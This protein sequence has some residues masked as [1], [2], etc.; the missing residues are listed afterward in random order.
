M[1]LESTPTHTLQFNH[2][3]KA[4]CGLMPECGLRA[5]FTPSVFPAV[6]CPTRSI[7]GNVL[8]CS[9]CQ[10]HLDPPFL[11]LSSIYEAEKSYQE[12]HHNPQCIWISTRA[13][14]SHEDDKCVPAR[15]VPHSFSFSHSKRTFRASWPWEA[16]Q[17]VPWDHL[18]SLSPSLQ[19]PHQIKPR[20][21][22][23][24][25]HIPFRK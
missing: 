7:L 1:S 13:L 14:L 15:A 9:I 23:S 5:G 19:P 20:V 25:W 8:S 11:S 12:A 21:C 24:F 4:E 18:I 17:R 22:A 3:V 16:K 2:K 10:R 6:I